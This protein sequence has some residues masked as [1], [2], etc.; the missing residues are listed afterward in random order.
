MGMVWIQPAWADDVAFLLQNPSPQQLVS[1][2]ARAICVAQ[3]RLRKLGVTMNFRTGKS[4]VILQLRGAGT[5]ALRRPLLIEQGCWLEFTNDFGSKEHIRISEHYTHLGGCV[6]PSGTLMPELQQRAKQARLT[7]RSLLSPVFANKHVPRATKRTVFMQLIQT[8]LLHHAST[9]TFRT[10]QEHQTFERLCLRLMRQANRRIAAPTKV[11]VSDQTVVNGMQLLW[12][13]ELLAIERLRYFGMALRHGPAILWAMIRAEA[14]WLEQLRQD[15][16][17]AFEQ[18]PFQGFGGVLSE[19]DFTSVDVLASYI[20]TLARHLRQRRVRLSLADAWETDMKSGFEEISSIVF[21]EK[22]LAYDCYQ[23]ALLNC[24]ECSKSFCGAVNLAVHRHRAHK[25]FSALYPF[26]KGTSC[27]ACLREYHSTS[28]LRE[29]LRSSPACV[30]RMQE[31]EMDFPELAQDV[32]RS[33]TAHKPVVRLQGPLAWWSLLDPT[34]SQ[35]ARPIVPAQPR[36]VC[37]AAGLAQC[38]PT[39]QGAGQPFVQHVPGTL[40]TLRSHFGAGETNSELL[41][42]QITEALCILAQT[43]DQTFVER[44]V[45]WVLLSDDASCNSEKH[46]WRAVH[47]QGQVVVTD[48]AHLGLTRLTRQP[49]QPRYILSFFCMSK[50]GYEQEVQQ[51]AAVFAAEQGIVVECL[52]ISGAAPNSQSVEFVEKLIR[53]G[54]V[55]ACVAVP[56]SDTWA[57]DCGACPAIQSRRRLLRSEE[58]PWG[59]AQLG[60]RAESAWVQYALRTFCCASHAALRV[61]LGI[62]RLPTTLHTHQSGS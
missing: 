52:S 50:R 7:L 21:T 55:A 1:D 5:A 54:W 17:W 45:A 34:D 35:T 61:L 39:E 11:P 20:K 6:V 28:R 32:I 9:W 16:R 2:V 18:V 23:E 30:V 8:K 57:T 26:A 60:V 58:E 22:G 14:R 29:H 37:L 47:H 15:L 10:A 62:L 31:A 51:Q 3:S 56:P 12:P 46:A 59:V 42:A 36:Q 19:S 33:H 40:R 13:K 43:H 25:Q 53:Q 4:E 41:A 38:L 24:P 48:L 27:V 44:T 49:A